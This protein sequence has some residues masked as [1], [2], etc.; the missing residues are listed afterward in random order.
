MFNNG[1][2]LPILLPS[3]NK[4]FQI[5]NI[6]SNKALRKSAQIIVSTICLVATLACGEGNGAHI[7]SIASRD[8]LKTPPCRREA[9]KYTTSGNDI[10]AIEITSAGNY[11]VIPTMDSIALHNARKQ[12]SI[13]KVN[14]FL[15]KKTV[16]GAE[17]VICG[18]FTKRSKGAFTLENYGSLEHQTG[19][20]LKLTAEKGKSYELDCIASIK[21]NS[22]DKLNASV[23]RTW[24][25]T[26][27]ETFIYD[28]DEKE[29]DNHTFSSE[30]MSRDYSKYLI[31][32]EYGTFASIDKDGKTNSI[33]KWKWSDPTNKIFRYRYRGDV[34]NYGYIQVDFDGTTMYL[35]ETFSEYD[36]KHL[37]KIKYVIISRCKPVYRS[38]LK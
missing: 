26:E 11:M 5:M 33:G 18:R 34:G 32:T 31:M 30:T 23:C 14:T 9:V 15:R 25:L 36:I 17:N 38:N 27:V 12:F 1:K 24:E 19:N 10:A 8:T 16:N 29:L 2:L 13:N 20:K 21:R 22:L 6:A 3:Q 28:E 35:Q 7:P 4:K 37:Q